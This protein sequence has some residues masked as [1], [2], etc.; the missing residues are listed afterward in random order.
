MTKWVILSIWR[1][2]AKGEALLAWKDVWRQ[3]SVIA[4]RGTE[5]LMKESK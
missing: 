5:F 4:Q 3:P 2:T 1:G